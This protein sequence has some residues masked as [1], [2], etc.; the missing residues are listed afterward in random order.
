MKLC[1]LYQ[2]SNPP[3]IKNQQKP[4]KPGGYS[5]SGADIA[6]NLSKKIP[7]ITPK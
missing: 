7:L 2:K 3:V 4:L 1:V 5:D 6:F